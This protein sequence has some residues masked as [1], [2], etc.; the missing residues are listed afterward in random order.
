MVPSESQAFVKF[1]GSTNF[2]VALDFPTF[3][4]VDSAG[5]H[6]AVCYPAGRRPSGV[7]DG[8]VIYI[9]RL[10]GDPNDI[11]IFGCA[12]ALRHQQGRDEATREDIERRDWKRW[13]PIYIRVHHPEFVAGTMA[14]AVSLNELMDELGPLSFKSTKR[15]AARGEGNVDPRRAYMRQP[16]V[17]LSEEGHAWVDERLE[18]VFATYGKIPQN[19]L[20]EL[21]WPDS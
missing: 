6:W 2:R 21:D 9:G 4:E 18:A 8:A 19:Q 14:N 10:T 15:N 1:L 20:A 7:R 3:G 17:A 13:W 12:V 11:R 5:C 16:A